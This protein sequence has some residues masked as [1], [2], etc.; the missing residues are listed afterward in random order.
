MFT[1]WTYLYARR[2]C[3]TEYPT[4]YMYMLAYATEIAHF[5]AVMYL[6]I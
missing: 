6:C 2:S 4:I 3:N 1:I 5:Y